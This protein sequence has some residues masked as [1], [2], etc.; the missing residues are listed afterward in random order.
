MRKLNAF[1]FGMIEFRSSLTKRYE[2]YS[3]AISY[4]HGRSLA[5]T[6]TFDRY[7]ENKNG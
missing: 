2:D 3:L 6:L 7:E 4:D 5:H 1:L